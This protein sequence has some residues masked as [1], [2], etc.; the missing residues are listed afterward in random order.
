M[1]SAET[2]VLLTAFKTPLPGSQRAHTI[3][4]G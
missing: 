1:E 2:A 4:E 3:L